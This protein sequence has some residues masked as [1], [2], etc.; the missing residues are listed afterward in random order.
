MHSHWQ[1]LKSCRQ[2]L[3][4]SHQGLRQPRL[5]TSAAATLCPH[6]WAQAVQHDGS[7]M[8]APPLDTSR[9]CMTN[10]EAATRLQQDWCSLPWQSDWKKRDF[11]DTHERQQPCSNAGHANAVQCCWR[12]AATMSLPVLTESPQDAETG[13]PSATSECLEH[14]A[15]WFTIGSCASRQCAAAPVRWRMY[16]PCCAALLPG[17]C[18]QQNHAAL[19]S[20]GVTQCER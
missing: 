14:G 1:Q 17:G 5:T 3:H 12:P 8:A 7:H 18:R 20:I 16:M 2:Q 11:P 13:H 9:L 10:S 15:K 19:L 6:P 4:S